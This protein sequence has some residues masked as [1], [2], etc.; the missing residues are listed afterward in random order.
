MKINVPL[1]D[2]ISESLIEILYGAQFSKEHCVCG[3]GEALWCSVCSEA[4]GPGVRSSPLPPTLPPHM[5]AA[6]RQASCSTLWSAPAC[7]PQSAKPLA[8]T[9]LLPI[10]SCVVQLFLS[11]SGFS[12]MVPTSLQPFHLAAPTL[13]SNPKMAAHQQHGPGDWPCFHTTR[14]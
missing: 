4:P 2:G 14:L 10:T 13:A 9:S 11:P 3:V 6:S 5:E 8:G 1:F 12:H 7:F